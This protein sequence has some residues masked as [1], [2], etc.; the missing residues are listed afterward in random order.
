MFGLREKDSFSFGNGAI[1]AQKR[2][3]I[4]KTVNSKKA[5]EKGGQYGRRDDDEKVSVMK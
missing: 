5:E 1:M 4:C 2:S 3:V